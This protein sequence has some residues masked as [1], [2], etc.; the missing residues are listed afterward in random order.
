MLSLQ[1]KTYNLKSKLGIDF[2]NDIKQIKKIKTNNYDI[3][4]ELYLKNNVSFKDDNSFDVNYFNDY[5]FNNGLLNK[6]YGLLY[7]NGDFSIKK[8]DN[9]LSDEEFEEEFDTNKHKNLEKRIKNILGIEEQIDLIF[10]T[11]EYNPGS[12]GT[13]DHYD[14]AKTTIPKTQSFTF[15]IYLN[16]L[17]HLD[18]GSTSFPNCGVDIYPKRGM[19]ICFNSHDESGNIFPDSLHRGSA[20]TGNKKKNILTSHFKV[21][22]ISF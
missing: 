3:E 8:Y 21:P 20:I 5:S 4:I 16:T 19:A 17:E 15:I 18:G 1:Q 22:W 6:N 2:E 9:F 12:P 7:K 10:H 14:W 13:G 11:G